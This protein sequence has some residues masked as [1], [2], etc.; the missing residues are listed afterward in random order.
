MKVTV[1]LENATP[2][3]RL[4]ARH[5][6]AL[7]VEAAGRRILFDMG[8]DAAFLANAEELGIDVATADAAV[9]SHGHA[10]HGG[11]LGAYL[12]AA[13]ARSAQA[14]VFVR[15][16]AFDVH[17]SGSGER[18]HAISLDPALAGAAR[19]VTVTEDALDIAPGL[20]LFATTA[21]PHSEPASNA[22]LF[23]VP[24]EAP[25]G[26]PSKPVATPGGDA[27]GGAPANAAGAEVVADDFSHEQ[28]LLVREGGRTVLIS[29]CS[30]AGIL[31]IMDEA[32]RLAARPLDAVVAG[33]HLMAPSAL[34]T[35]DDTTVRALARELAAHPA[36]YFTFHC[37][38]LAA[39][40]VL[41]D[42]LG[43]RVSYLAC[44]STVEL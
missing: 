14:P 11:G 38:G 41:R 22:R 6:L 42:E 4:A 40:S 18:R 44:G 5:G 43:P 31:N 35:A 17:L 23:A 39:Y 19:L 10:D 2:T 25:D 30:H 7:W 32:E 36:R 15:A 3:S 37:T 28:S 16:H 34:S 1:L 8:P 33:F 27:L 13:D 26:A 21:R 29:A 24:G 12:A 9:L 20:T